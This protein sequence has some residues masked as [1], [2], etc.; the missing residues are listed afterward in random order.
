MTLLSSTNE[1]LLWYRVFI[2]HTGGG[3]RQS[4]KNKSLASGFRP[5]WLGFR[6]GWL[7]LRPGW[8]TQRVERT[9]GGR[10]HEWMKHPHSTGLRPLSGPLTCFPH[11]NQEYVCISFNNTFYTFDTY[12]SKI[13]CRAGSPSRQNTLFFS[14]KNV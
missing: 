4:S 11:E 2:N 1:D 7:G 8:M 6:P 10:T 14:Y 5:G 13:F 3:F 12:P 9:D